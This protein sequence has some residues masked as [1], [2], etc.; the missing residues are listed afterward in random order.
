M[1]GKHTPGGCTVVGFRRDYSPT[2]PRPHPRN[3]HRAN[4]CR[5]ANVPRC[6]CPA[7]AHWPHLDHLPI[8]S[9]LRAARV[10]Q[11][12]VTCVATS[13]TGNSARRG[14]PAHSKMVVRRRP[15]DDLIIRVAG[16]RGFPFQNG[17]GQL[18]FLIVRGR[19]R[20]HQE[21]VLR[22]GTDADL[23]LRLHGK[24]AFLRFS[25]LRGHAYPHARTSSSQDA[26]LAWHVPA[27]R[28]GTGNDY[29]L[30]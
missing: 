21:R 25:N 6:S 8:G 7:V 24:A 22:N 15:P 1:R 13:M 29:G 20:E 12:A 16:D 9:A 27:H 5:D 11:K 30:R 10:F 23:Q 28:S 18:G 2:T 26:I 3:R 14:L 17:L 4:N 19:G